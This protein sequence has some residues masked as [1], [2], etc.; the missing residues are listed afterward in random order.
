M[1]DQITHC[2]TF[3]A[4]NFNR[5]ETNGAVGHEALHSTVLK[6]KPTFPTKV[7]SQNHLKQR[8]KYLRV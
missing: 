8:G 3:L 2:F 4:H 7:N 1:G 5:E 6:Y